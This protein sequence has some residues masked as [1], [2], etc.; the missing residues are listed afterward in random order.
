[1]EE[2]NGDLSGI[3]DP[4]G[5]AIQIYD[6][7]TELPFDGNIIPQDRISSQARSLLS[8]FPLPNVADSGRYN[9]QIPL[10]EELHGDGIR[11]RFSLNPI[12]VQFNY[13]TTRSD[14][15]NAFGFLDTGRGSSIDMTLN[16]NRSFNRFL[17]LNLQYRFE[18]MTAKTV[19]YFA[20][21]LNVSGD[22][23]ITGNNQDPIN[24][25]PPNLSFSNYE[26]LSEARYSFDR[27]RKDSVSAAVMMIRG[28]HNIQIGS[29]YS[30]RQ[31]N[32]MSQQNARGTF[33]FTGTAAGYDFAGF[34][35]GIPDAAEIAFGN[36]DKY[37]RRSRYAAY[38]ND[39]WY[40]GASL[41]LNIGIRWE[42]E[43]P[44]TERY[45]SLVNLDIAPGF[46]AVSPAIASDPTGTSTC[47]Q[48]PDSLFHP[49]KGGFQPRIGFAWR[50]RAASSLVVRGGYG[51]YCDTSAYLSIARQ[52]S[53]QAPLSKS[54]SIANSPEHPLTIANV[55]YGP[56]EDYIGTFAVDPD[57]R[58]ARSQNWQ[59]SGQ[60]DL[61]F[62]MQTVVTY[63][64]SKGT[65]IIQKSLP[66]T[67]P[68]GATD[69][70]PGCPSGFIYAAP[71]DLQAAWKRFTSD[72]SQCIAS[73]SPCSA[74]MGAS[75]A[76]S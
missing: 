45:G 57:F 55:F 24:W 31:L 22:T 27:D 6:P 70:C 7:E 64:G 43:A 12:S 40:I 58:S 17:S 59:L 42:Y 11:G 10:M 60:R 29:D 30:R 37:F 36:A 75:S 63:M 18:R 61:P 35:L 21:R 47:R 39:N 3:R 69:A 4:S 48:Y 13:Q 76:H 51:I 15:P 41:T 28:D 2:R 53:Q 73:T 26:N 19:P 67:Y 14:N 1:M 49:D 9:F 46:E 20:D 62:S 8:L 65:R 71:T 44:F 33:T 74:G 68:E 72:S 16:Y 66:N 38:I 23:G 56:V 50:P 5:R 32:T 34:L 54:L 25:G 52:M